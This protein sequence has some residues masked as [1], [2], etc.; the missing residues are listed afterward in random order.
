MALFCSKETANDVV[1]ELKD[2]C[3]D[4]APEFVRASIAAIGYIA[5]RIPEAA[6]QCVKT[7]MDM[8]NGEEAV[9]GQAKSNFRLPS[10][11]A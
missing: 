3:E 5:C 6:D 4:V 8:L 10:Y 2:Y 1:K 11:A 7:Y 9:E